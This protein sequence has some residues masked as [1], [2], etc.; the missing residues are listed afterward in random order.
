MR[1]LSQAG[2]ISQYTKGIV[3]KSLFL[4]TGHIISTLMMILLID[5]LR[6]SISLVAIFTVIFF[7]IN[8]VCASIV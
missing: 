7:I 1:E 2:K 8:D 6:L 4:F 3:E 5:F